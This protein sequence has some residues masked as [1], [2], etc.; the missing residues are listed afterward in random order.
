[1]KISPTEH[2]RNRLADSRLCVR[3]TSSAIGC[4]SKANTASNLTVRAQRDEQG[5]SSVVDARLT[6][7]VVPS[8]AGGGFG[9]D[10]SGR[11]DDRRLA[12]LAHDEAKR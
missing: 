9:I 2:F 1:M 3:A 7:A 4:H 5:S 6:A 12:P 11:R 8:G 10:G